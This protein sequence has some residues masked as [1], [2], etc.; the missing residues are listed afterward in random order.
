[1]ATI[2]QNRSV[3]IYDSNHSDIL[4]QLH[5]HTVSIQSLDTFKGKSRFSVGLISDR[6][7]I[8]YSFD[9]EKG[10]KEAELADTVEIRM[11]QDAGLNHMIDYKIV[12]ATRDSLLDAKS[13]SVTAFAVTS[14]QFN[15][16]F[17]P[18]KAHCNYMDTILPYA[19]LPHALY[20]GEILESKNDIFIYYREKETMFSVFYE[21]EFVY[22]KSMVGGVKALY[23]T[24]VKNN[25][26]HV[27]YETFLDC[28][29]QN[30]LDSGRY[31][32]NPVVYHQDVME[33]MERSLSDLNNVIQ[34]A[35]RIAGIQ[36]FDRIF[37]GT[38]K[39]T[40]PELT[41]LVRNISGIRGESFEFFTPFYHTEDAYV[42][43]NII[44]AL[45]EADNILQGR[46]ANPFNLSI[47]P[48][49][50]RFYKR[51]SG[52]LLLVTAAALGLSMAYPLYLAVDTHWKTYAYDSTIAKLQISQGE[53]LE[54][55]A[56]EDGYKAKK[57]HYLSLLQDEKA[58]LDR[59]L[60]LFKAIEAKR[61]TANT[62]TFT[63]SRLF[64]AVNRHNLKIE[65]I[66]IQE[67]RFQLALRAKKDAYVTAF[68]KEV[69][70][71]KT[72]SVDMDAYTFNP[73]IRQ[74]QTLITIKVAL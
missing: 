18:F 11:F 58:Q 63:L 10:L 54:L 31:G 44:L 33:V 40:V 3:L 55:K 45:I 30:G 13:L 53:F 46:A 17:G 20:A 1:M 16:E 35:R 26:E 72:F 34:Y 32:E 71:E 23:D 38:E 56:K 67:N 74:Y 19:T 39:G 60:E 25:N 28:L 62:K 61:M 57:E 36:G 12:Y 49:P 15:G 21:G 29:I 9:V 73:E 4:Y 5:D 8:S 70:S 27:T 52:K 2:P 48:R 41:T 47:Y 14:S 51:D 7:I 50:P 42:D 65:R 64:D 37:I 68:L 22:A 6:E 66:D 59:Y 69:T 43:Q 24:F